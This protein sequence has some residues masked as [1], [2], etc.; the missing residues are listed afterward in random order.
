MGEALAAVRSRERA[1]L[2]VAADLLVRLGAVDPELVE[3][4]FGTARLAASIAVFMG[5]SEDDVVRVQA[6][7]L[8]HE[9]GALSVPRDDLQNLGWARE[10]EVMRI[11]RVMRRESIAIV[12]RH[13]DLADLAGYIGM[14]YD[15]VVPSIVAKIVVVADQF[16]ALLRP[17]V[18][19]PPVAPA[20]AL[21]VL[22]R[23]VGVRYDAKVF[24]ALRTIVT[25]EQPL[26][27]SR[28]SRR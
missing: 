8:L 16:D 19:R 25:Q 23:L 26:P 12:S 10:S 18:S 9:I 13:P 1:A 21:S 20:E 24:G 7:G 2:D 17:C 5:L 14:V 27:M 11:Q 3:H 6:T 4:S 22:S 28:R 15:D